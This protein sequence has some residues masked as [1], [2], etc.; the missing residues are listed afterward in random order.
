MTAIGLLAAGPA[1]AAEADSGPVIV[2]TAPSAG[3]SIALRDTPD[4]AQVLRGDALARQ[5]HATLADL[6]D[7]NLGSVSLSNGSGSPYQ[8]DLAYRG[9]QATSLLGSP[10][11]LSV[12]V[13]GVRMNEPFGGNVN[14]DLIPM[15]AI[16]SVEVL[17]GSNPLFGL[18]TLGGALVVATRNG[19]DQGGLAGTVQGGSFHRRAVLAEAGGTLAG[20]A[21]DWYVAGN[22]DRQ[23]GYRWYTHANVKQLYGKLRWH[24]ADADVELGVSWA[25]TVLHGTQALPLSLLGTPRMAYTW[26]DEVANRQLI[27]NL[28]G[29]RRISAA[30]RISGNVYYRRANASSVNS[31]AGLDDGCGSALDCSQAAPGGTAQDLY[32]HN[33]YL[34]GSP[35]AGHFT[36]YAGALPIHDYTGAIDTTLALST[37]RQR[38][39]GGNALLDIDGHLLGLDHD[40]NLGASFETARIGYDQNTYLA[41]LVQYQTVPMPWNFRYGSAA[42]F[43]GDPLVNSVALAARNSSANVFMRDRISLT[44]KLGLTGSLSYTFTHIGLSGANTTRLGTDGGYSW[45]GADGQSWYNPAYLGALSWITSDTAPSALEA[46]GVPAGGVA[47]P[48]V[49]PLSGAHDYHRLNPAIGLS[50]NP[51]KAIGFFASYSEALRAPT[52]IELAC[53]D[54]AK[55]CALPTGFNGDPALAAVVAHTIEA[56]ARGSWTR[57]IG[58]NIAVYR[59]RLDNDIQFIYNASGLGYF[60]NVGA[61]ERR[62]FEMAL[63]ADGRHWHLTASYG[64]VQATFR[65][66]FTDAHGDAVTPGDH[67]PGIPARSVKLRAVWTPGRAMAL[68]ASLIATGSQ[69]AHGDEANR[70][71]VVP[72]YAIVNL[73]GQLRPLP[74]LELFATATNLFDRHYASFG[75][76][77]GNIYSGQPEQFRT[78][79]APRAF[80]LG[81]RYSLGRDARGDED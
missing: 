49:D 57:A 17:P 11:E 65:S 60:A 19:A 67:I 4:N 45:T 71:G 30:V 5:N 36:A 61:T 23:D 39:F 52:A 78:P 74:R 72:G 63:T 7:A 32:R 26:P 31:N 10:T 14:W 25:E 16:A 77:G 40:Y 43:R 56:G 51:G 1:L 28:K 27:I 18:N 15:N 33:P 35:A 12:Y 53:A 2:V 21:L 48:E 37:T 69:Y 38:I 13:D 34:A 24:G 29:D 42:G 47:G 58:W 41:A 22:A 20:K 80:L 9:F 79:A 62:G 66:G 68:G 59:T 50:W 73:D 64:A 76:M 8:N 46:A 55:P 54:P 81:L 6:L 70:N 3:D 44:P 75:V